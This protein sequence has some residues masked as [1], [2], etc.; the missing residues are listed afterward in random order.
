[1]INISSML[2]T[3]EVASQDEGWRTSSDSFLTAVINQAEWASLPAINHPLD[4][5]EQIHSFC[6]GLVPQFPTS[7]QRTVFPGC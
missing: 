5:N 2:C 4:S 6:T 3:N 7:T 1:M